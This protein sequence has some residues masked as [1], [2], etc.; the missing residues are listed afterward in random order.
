MRDI[1]ITTKEEES[2]FTINGDTPNS[3]L[4]SRFYTLDESP[5]VSSTY[6][7][8]RWKQIEFAL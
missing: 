6:L 8:S 2:I 4:P 5:S 3:T 7:F 1:E